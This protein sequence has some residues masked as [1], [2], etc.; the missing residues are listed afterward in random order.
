MDDKPE[1]NLQTL[2]YQRIRERI[3]FCN[4]TPGQKISARLLEEELAVGRTPI[5]ES[6]VRLGEQ[7]LVYT[8]PQ[9]GT[10]VSKISL[11]AA[12][13]ARFVREH[14]ERTVCAECCARATAAD[15]QRL[16]EL[17]DEQEAARADEANRTFFERDNAFHEE[18][19]RIANRSDVWAWINTGNTHLERF[20]WLRTQ[21]QGLDW[22]GI[23]GQHRML[24]DALVAREPEEATY[25]ASAH[26]HLMV[27]EQDAVVAAFPDYFDER[28]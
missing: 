27:H 13:N 25:I 6:L 20:R 10:Y 19:F 2:A 21:V 22:R 14:L 23:I 28:A 4:L 1:V 11:H 15:H 9:S 7:G 26:L 5:R 16:A 8:I 18:L 12:E 17:I 24:L 3:I